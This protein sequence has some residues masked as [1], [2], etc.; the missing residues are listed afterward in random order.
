[1]AGVDVWGD[2]GIYDERWIVFS[3]IFG[4]IS[5]GEQD[6]EKSHQKGL[7]PEYPCQTEYL[8]WESKRFL[9]AGAFTSRLREGLLLGFCVQEALQ[10]WPNSLDNKKSVV[11]LPWKKEKKT[12]NLCRK[13]FSDI[14]CRKSYIDCVYIVAAVQ[15]FEMNLWVKDKY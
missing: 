3:K 5:I 2:E 10:D 7:H 12:Y 11:Q 6:E 15:E 14:L 1:M 8:L 4:K 13:R 9:H